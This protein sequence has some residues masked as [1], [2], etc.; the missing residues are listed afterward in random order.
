MEVVLWIIGA[1]GAEQSD[2]TVAK[3]SMVKSP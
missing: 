3:G 2:T 1:K